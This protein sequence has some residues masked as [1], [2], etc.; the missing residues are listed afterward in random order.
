[1]RKLVNAVLVS[2]LLALLILGLLELQ[3]YVKDDAENIALRDQVVKVSKED[4]GDPFDRFIDFDALKQMN[5][6][7]KGWVYVPGTS[8][9]YPILVGR[10]DT[11]YLYKNYKGRY[12]SIGAIFSYAGVD[13]TYDSHVCL[14]GHNMISGKMF[15]ELRKYKEEGYALDRLKAYVYT[16]DRTKELSLVSVFSCNKKDPIFEVVNK[17]ADSSDVTLLN[18][19][20]DR[21]LVRTPEIT[22]YSGQIYSLA[23]CDG[24]NGTSKR[25]TVHYAVTREKY[26][27]D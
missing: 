12:S 25:M 8:I 15:S 5:P 26:N 1:M 21:S 6:D 23:T 2:L 7:I 10:T 27:I 4:P 18:S 9:D 17:R 3:K 19:V 16:P 22:N 20:R 24:Y 11:E 14:F 13:V